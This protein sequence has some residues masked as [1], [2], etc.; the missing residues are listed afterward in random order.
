MVVVVVLAVMRVMRC[1]CK[2]EYI[3][4][5]ENNLVWKEGSSGCDV[6]YGER[7]C[8]EVMV[9][10]CGGGGVMGLLAVL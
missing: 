10:W 7:V 1:L 3:G 2:D 9:L 6:S 5:G 8:T 4:N